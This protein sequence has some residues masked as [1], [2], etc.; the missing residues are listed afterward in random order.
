MARRPTYQRQAKQ[1]KRGTVAASWPGPLSPQEVAAKATY[2]CS[3]EH[4][5]YPS[6]DG[7]WT[8][9]PR[10]D[11]AKCDKYDRAHWPQL[12]DALRAAILAGCVDE[13]FR[14]NFPARVWAYINDVLH[15][16][17]LSN[18]ALGQYHGFP[19][20]YEEHRPQDP[21]GLLRNAPHATIPHH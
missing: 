8:F 1:I 7:S 19:V 13:D 21:L 15:E 10:A 6:D 2:L 4:K 18:A 12:V 16:A 14:G 20:E 3:G 9:D 17:R 11:K 5:T